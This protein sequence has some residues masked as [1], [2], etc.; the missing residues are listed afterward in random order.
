M[1]P[2]HN[3][4]RTYSC[5]PAMRVSPRDLDELVDAV[6]LA[7]LRGLPIRAAGTGHSLMPLAATSGCLITTDHLTRILRIDGD[8]IEVEAGALLIDVE[9]AAWEVGLSLEGGTNYARMTVGGIVATGAHGSSR[10]KGTLSSRVVAATIVKADG[11]V[12]RVDA[13]TPDALRAA[14]LHLGML[15]VVYALE[16][17]CE[18]AFHMRVQY[19]PE[20]LARAIADVDTVLG[21]HDH[22]SLYWYPGSTRAWWYLADRT[23]GPATLTR[24]RIALRQAQ[25]LAL[26]K[27]AGGVIIPIVKRL[28]RLTHAL[29]AIG[30]RAQQR[31]GGEVR[32][33]VDAFHYLWHT[34]PFSDAG[35][36]FGAE[37]AGAA[38]EATFAQ[39]ADEAGRGRFPV[40]MAV[41]LRMIGPDDAFLSPTLGRPAVALECVSGPGTRDVEPF[42]RDFT[43]LMADRFGGRPHWGKQFYEG[44]R[45][46]VYGER[47][48]QFD[49][50]RRAFDPEGAF[51]NDLCRDIL[52]DARV[53]LTSR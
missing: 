38:L 11:S 20:P 7:R 28:P 13:S 2:W 43:A 10:E 15:G 35:Q 27:G 44:A 24:R 31:I 42:F 21:A 4:A 16:L 41:Q 19:R 25:Q 3:W 45:L 23:A 8:T 40:N 36:I 6:K 1:Q 12:V 48:A 22:V 50:I 18:P 52:G 14:R 30:D 47:R 37:H 32:R 53:A 5:G 29:L 33:S 34:P 26:N 51:L 46:D 39:L 9:E 17:R 49:R